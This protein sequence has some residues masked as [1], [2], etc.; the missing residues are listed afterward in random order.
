M[1]FVVSVLS[2]IPF[3]IPMPKFQCRGLQMA[4]KNMHYKNT[5]VNLKQIK[6]PTKVSSLSHSNGKNKSSLYP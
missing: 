4:I 3:P 5:D 6:L 2:P 1:A